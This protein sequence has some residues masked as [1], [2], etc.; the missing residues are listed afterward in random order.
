MTNIEELLG[1]IEE[2]R[3]AVEQVVNEQKGQVDGPPFKIA[4]VCNRLIE[5][6]PK[7][8]PDGTILLMCGA[9]HMCTGTQWVDCTGDTY[10]H[11]EMIRMIR[12]ALNAG[13]EVVLLHRS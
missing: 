12:G 5:F 7:K 8:A 10:T 9:E 13:A 2:L 4:E 6:D 1:Q 11:G 3:A